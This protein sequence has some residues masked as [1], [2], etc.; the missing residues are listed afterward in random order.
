MSDLLEPKDYALIGDV[1]SVSMQFYQNILLIN[2]FLQMIPAGGDDPDFLQHQPH[3]QIAGVIER[4]GRIVS[5]G[6]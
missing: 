6:T 1:V 4:V 3:I 5:I 2:A